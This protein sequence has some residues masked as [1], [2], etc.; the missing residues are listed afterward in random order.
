[1]FLSIRG[2]FVPVQNHI[3][4][5]TERPQTPALIQIQSRFSWSS[6]HDGFVSDSTNISMYKIKKGNRLLELNY[7]IELNW[8][9][10]RL[11]W[12]YQNVLEWRKCSMVSQWKESIHQLLSFTNIVFSRT[13]PHPS[14]RTRVA[15]RAC[16]CCGNV[17]RLCCACS[18]PC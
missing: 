10:L 5:H 15:W 1:M 11:P 9:I 4:I 18:P 2:Q 13:V 17:V 14:H 6:K 16:G 3:H 7:K 8:M 12:S